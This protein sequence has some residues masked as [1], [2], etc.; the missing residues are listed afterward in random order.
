[1]FIDGIFD[2]AFDFNE[3]ALSVFLHQSSMPGIYRNYVNTL[4]VNPKNI[5]S[6][7]EIPFLPISFF[8]THIIKDENATTEIIFSSSGTTGN[9]TSSHYVTDLDL[10]IKSFTAGFK[11]FYGDIK[12]Y[13]FLALLPSYLK[14][15]GSSLVFMCDHLI[16]QSQHPLSGFYLDQMKELQDTL[17]MLK[18][19][20]QP[21]ILLG[22]TYALLDLAEK[23]HLNF[24]ELIIIETGGMKGRRKE[25]IREEVHSI[26]KRAFSVENIHSEY[27]MTELLSQA[28][29]KED[30]IFK[31]PPWMQI[32]IRDVNDPFQ[33]AVHNTTGAINIIDLANIHSC[34]FIATDDLGRKS[35]DHSFEIL[36]RLESSDLRGCNL[37]VG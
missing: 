3:K 17:K 33:L 1:M 28:W 10:Y 34:S 22:V 32:F 5:K 15:N 9:E 14:R 29:S 2:S 36:G 26:L 37:L 13:C 11:L 6:I 23:F 16:K 12:N 25:M 27:G 18:Q 20:N 30:G 4:N 8:K 35:N 19:Q 24:P 7:E 31:C 21:V